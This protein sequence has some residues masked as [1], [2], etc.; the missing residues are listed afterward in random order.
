MTA[1]TPQERLRIALDLAG[2]GEQMMRARLRR[3]QPNI[4]DEDLEAAVTRWLQDRPG[5]P[6]GDCPGQP[7]SRIL[8]G[9]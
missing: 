2:V 8:P 1:A 7:R 3:E 5:A 6:A 9:G 4:T